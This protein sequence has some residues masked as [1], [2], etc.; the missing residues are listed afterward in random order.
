MDECVFCRIAEKKIPCK[1][2][3]ED[4]STMAFLDI[5]PGASGH[6][7]VIPKVH[8][9]T[10]FDLSDDEICA[11]FRTVAKM[12]KAIDRTIKPDGINVFQNNRPAAGQIVNHMH[13][14]IFPRFRGDGID[15]KWRR[16]V[17]D[18][19]DLDN[20]ANRIRERIE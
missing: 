1:F 8:H 16:V 5:N 10:I 7:L 2:I 19:E 6:T 14:H 17:L 9:E 18:S 20:I 13:V 3:Y 4:E 15:F 11:L 12:T